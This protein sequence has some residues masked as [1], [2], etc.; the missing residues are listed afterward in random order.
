MTPHTEFTRRS[1][2]NP[3]PPA[4]ILWLCALP[5]EN[6]YRNVPLDST[7]WSQ[8]ITELALTKVRSA[9]DV[10]YD[11]SPSQLDRL[12]RFAP[13]IVV[14]RLPGSWGR[15]QSNVGIALD[16]DLV[17]ATDTTPQQIATV[18]VHELTHARL[19]AAGVRYVDAARV[20]CERICHLAE[21]NF[22]ARLPASKERA[23]LEEIS[24]RYLIAGPQFWSDA[25]FVDRARAWRSR[26][27]LWLRVAH[28]V[29]DFV[30]RGHRAA[31]FG[32]R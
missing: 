27:R 17:L 11:V 26:Q 15:W 3:A 13:R 7:I 28:D 1:S 22:I 5:A 12:P 24:A 30:L 9:L 10:L 21:R 19:E 25:A 32:V 23:R 8:P 6:V 16:R 2:A 20:R 18:I 4:W 31:R 29:G 14:A